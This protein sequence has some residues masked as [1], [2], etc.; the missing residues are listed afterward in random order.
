MMV[1]TAL[2]AD[3]QEHVVSLPRMSPVASELD[4]RL[5]PEE[6]ENGS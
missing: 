5:T 6:S 3:K 4:P 2:P 1:R